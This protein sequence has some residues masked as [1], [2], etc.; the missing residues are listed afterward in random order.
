[1][2]TRVTVIFASFFLL[3]STCAKAPKKSTLPRFA[4]SITGEVRTFEFTA[5]RYL[6]LIEANL[7][8]DVF[9]YIGWDR[10]HC[11]G[12]DSSD[13]AT[14]EVVPAMAEELPFPPNR[15]LFARQRATFR[16]S[17]AGRPG[18]S[19]G[20]GPTKGPKSP[21]GR[22][23]RPTQA[24]SKEEIPRSGHA[25]R[26]NASITSE[27]VM[28]KSLAYGAEHI[29]DFEDLEPETAV[30]SQGPCSSAV[31]V[32]QRATQNWPK[33]AV[34]LIEVEDM[35][36]F[37]RITTKLWGY[38]P[39]SHKC[40]HHQVSFVAQAHKIYQCQR[41][42]E[43]F[44]RYYRKG[45]EYDF[46]MHGRPDL[47]LPPEPLNFSRA[48]GFISSQYAFTSS[49]ALQ[50]TPE[51]RHVMA[52]TGD[53]DGIPPMRVHGAAAPPPPKRSAPKMLQANE[54]KG[55][56]FFPFAAISPV[57]LTSWLWVHSPQWQRTGDAFF[58]TMAEIID[59]APTSTK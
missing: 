28:G 35:D 58:S 1:M 42:I 2:I 27:M 57:S 40:N 46:I 43:D 18:R 5:P 48:L 16:H 26:S 8:T 7:E 38:G 23:S 13:N 52:E 36:P 37:P 3:S 12:M 9:F 14:A 24:E 11:A 39:G 10:Q 41:R 29:F 6:Q 56:I 20:P 53:D 54:N 4:I 47:L 15:T 31:A 22:Q 33:G 45:V 34:K 19:P 25:H 17:G 49:E 44:I 55:V 30:D 32:V 51:P 21:E 50:E 59:A